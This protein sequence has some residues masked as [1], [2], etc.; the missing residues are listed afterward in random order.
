MPIKQ[1]IAFWIVSSSL[2]VLAQPTTVHSTSACAERKP[3][4]ISNHLIKP[5]QPLAKAESKSVPTSCQSKESHE[6]S[7]SQVMQTKG[8]RFNVCGVLRPDDQTYLTLPRSERHKRT[9]K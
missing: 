3:L 5:E 2:P 4:P 6:P 8:T 9:S 7:I 1:L